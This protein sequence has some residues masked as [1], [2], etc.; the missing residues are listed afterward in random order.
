LHPFLSILTAV[1]L[2]FASGWL[3]KESGNDPG[4]MRWSSILSIVVLVQVLF[5]AATLFTL[6]PIIM[7]LGHLFLADAV[8]ISLVLLAAYFLASN[9]IVD[10]D[11]QQLP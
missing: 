6:A 7:Q 9:D 3:K 5:G 1:Y 10:V 8:W 4:V 11:G 2:I